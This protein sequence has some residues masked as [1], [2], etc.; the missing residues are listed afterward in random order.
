LRQGHVDD[1][2]DALIRSCGDDDDW[3]DQPHAE[4]GD[5]DTHGQKHFAP[6]LVHFLE[7]A[8]VHYCVVEGQ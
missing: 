6:E 5:Q 8:G 7:H 4:H 3:K 2:Y 1:G